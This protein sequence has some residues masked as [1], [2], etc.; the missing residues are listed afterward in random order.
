MILHMQENN[1]QRHRKDIEDFLM[2]NN[3]YVGFV[4]GTNLVVN[5]SLCKG[6]NIISVLNVSQIWLCKKYMMVKFRN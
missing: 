1:W 3:M 6:A 5:S 2:K 4:T